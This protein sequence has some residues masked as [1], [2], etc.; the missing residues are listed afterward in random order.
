MVGITLFDIVSTDSMYFLA[1]VISSCVSNYHVLVGVGT[2]T[3]TGTTD[4]ILH[5]VSCP[6]KS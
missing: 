3:K 4:I 2:A 1:G 5:E 6:P